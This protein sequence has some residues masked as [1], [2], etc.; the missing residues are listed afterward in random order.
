MCLHRTTSFAF[1]TTLHPS[2]TGFNCRQDLLFEQVIA[3]LNR[4]CLENL[5][6]DGHDTYFEIPMMSS[7]DGDIKVFETIKTACAV[8]GVSFYWQTMPDRFWKIGVVESAGSASHSH[9][10]AA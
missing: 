4:D 2:P 6:W 3:Q 10:F 8:H 7:F 1:T 9:A 5:E